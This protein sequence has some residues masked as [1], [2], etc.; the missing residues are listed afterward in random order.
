MSVAAD[1]VQRLDRRSVERFLPELDA[2]LLP[3]SVWSVQHTWPQLYRSDGDGAF[4]AILDG[5]RL[6]SHCACRVT[7]RDHGADHPVG[8]LGSVATAPDHRGRGLATR[9]LEAALDHLAPHTDAVLLWAERPE[10]Y[11][12]R[13]FVAVAASS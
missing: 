3:G 11:R 2:W 12:R 6:L 8:L 9:V 10:L 7:L 1:S 13:G 4:F 5:D